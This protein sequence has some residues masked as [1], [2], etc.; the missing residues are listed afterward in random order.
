MVGVTKKVFVA[1]TMETQITG[2]EP[3]TDYDNAFIKSYDEAVNWLN[4]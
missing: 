4:S 1:P 2:K 3:G